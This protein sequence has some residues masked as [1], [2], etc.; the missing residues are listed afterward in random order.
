MVAG[1][2][3]GHAGPGAAV[4]A[5]AAQKQ[6]QQQLE[7]QVQLSRE[8]IDQ[9]FKQAQI[10]HLNQQMFQSSQELSLKQQTAMEEHSRFENSM[11]QEAMK[12]PGAID[13]GVVKNLNDLEALHGTHPDLPKNLAQGS[14]FQAPHFSP[15]L[16]AKGNPT[17]EMKF[18]G[19]RAFYVPPDYLNQMTDHDVDVDI[20][21]KP[22]KPG[23]KG[24][25]TT[26]T[27]PAGKVTNGTALHAQMDNSAT[28]LKYENDSA[29]AKAQLANATAQYK[30]AQTAATAQGAA[31]LKAQATDNGRALAEGDLA[32]SQMNKR[33][34]GNYDASM[35]AAEAYSMQHYGKHFSREDAE[36]FYKD[37]QATIKNFTSGKDSDQISAFNTAIAHLDLL[38]QAA[39]AQGNGD[40][41]KLN[42]IAQNLARATGKPVP[43]TYDAIHAAVSGEV[44]SVY[45]KGAASEGEMERLDQVFHQ[46]QSPQAAQ[47]AINTT[48]GLML[49]KVQALDQKFRNGTR[50][51]SPQE[52]GVSL[53]SPESAEVMQRLGIEMPAKLQ[54]AAQTAGM[55]GAP[56]P[57]PNT[58]PPKPPEGMEK[59]VQVQL[60][61]QAPGWIPESALPK[62]QADHKDATVVH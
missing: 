1:A 9:K 29:V 2:G 38:G 3:Q 19:S 23:E 16:D 18:D 40:F 53:V 22:S 61:G 47:A 10:A 45:K 32:P 24:T 26:T 8:Q 44:G 28:M 27:L 39:Q 37:K 14:I 15:V 60:P 34:K 5:Q 55:G 4:G 12:A 50:G 11:S 57:P 36:I 42:D 33:G 25:F 20:F 59:P 17:G 52:Y 62:F 46:S 51:K 35:A 6:Q 21:Q 30:L 31:D 48:I 56:N 49:G 13:L 41:T 7:N 43:A 54:G 58:A